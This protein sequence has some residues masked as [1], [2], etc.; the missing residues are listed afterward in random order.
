[1][2]PYTFDDLVT[3]SCEQVASNRMGEY[4]YYVTLV[5]YFDHRG[6]GCRLPVPRPGDTIAAE[7][8]ISLMISWPDNATM[9]I[10]EV[11]LFDRFGETFIEIKATNSD[12]R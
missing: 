11:K 12:Y 9:T 10:R 5:R 7:K 2:K 3:Y 6:S 4:D 1:M 8:N